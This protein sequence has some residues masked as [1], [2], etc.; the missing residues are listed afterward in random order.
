MEIAKKIINGDSSVD[1]AKELNMPQDM[2]RPWRNALI[3]AGDGRSRM[4]YCAR[5]G[6]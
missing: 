6:R 4:K 2:S 5:I 1:V 3:W